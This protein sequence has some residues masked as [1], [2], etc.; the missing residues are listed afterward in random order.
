MKRNQNPGAG[1]FTPRIGSALF[2]VFGLVSPLAAQPVG[3]DAEPM[4]GTSSIHNH[5]GFLIEADPTASRRK[6]LP[7]PNE[8]L[9]ERVIDAV[10][11]IDS[12]R[13]ERLEENLRKQED[14]I[15]IRL[16]ALLIPSAALEDPATYAQQLAEASYSP[17]E[18]G[19][20]LVMTHP[21]GRVFLG[22]SRGLQT[23]ARAEDV[24]LLVAS[25]QD[26][27]GE[28]VVPAQLLAAAAERI[29]MRL[30]KMKSDDEQEKAASRQTRIWL[31]LI[32]AF[33]TSAL[34]IHVIRS[35]I[36]SNL[37]DR[38]RYFPVNAEP[39]ARLGGPYTGGEGVRR[40]YRD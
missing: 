10:G 33:L 14:R 11:V 24:N 2:A 28:G 23:F 31:V 34:L 38:K 4:M 1:G 15:G 27:A 22:Q 39:C 20:I 13:R 36:G 18:S 3:L 7:N 16:R 5:P 40:S 26:I 12:S 17:S 6:P 30:A 37:F 29:L 35:L 32:T 25:S 21:A 8:A 19:V 9:K